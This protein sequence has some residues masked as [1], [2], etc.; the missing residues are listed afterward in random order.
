MLD[1]GLKVLI[2]YLLGALNGSLVLGR[3][4]GGPDVRSVGSG[5]AGGTNALRARGKWF[6]LGVVVIDV[7]K[8]VVAAVN[9][10]ALSLPGLAAEPGLGMQI[11][12]LACAA[13]AVF[14][15][16]YPVW[17]GFQGGKGGATAVGALAGLAPW[18]LIPAFITWLVVVALTG[19]VG[20]ATM[21][22][23]A[24]LP[25]A[26]LLRG[27]EGSSAFIIFLVLLA[28]FIVYTHRSNIARMRSGQESRM[29]QLMLL[30]RS[31]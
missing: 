17:F 18:L 22:A 4:L 10:P 21:S 29:T 12:V 11:T 25:I 23:A 8:G 2:A 5:N 13:A 9:V 26:V 20:L 31:N 28:A 7:L 16:C 6:A 14:G 27:S 30:R 3:L 19:F 15:H 1:L 24:I